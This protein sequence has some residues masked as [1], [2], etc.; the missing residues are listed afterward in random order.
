ME[1]ATLRGQIKEMEKE[2]TD[3]EAMKEP[4]KKPQGSEDNRKHAEAAFHGQIEKSNNRLI[5]KK[6]DNKNL[7]IILHGRIE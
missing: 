3:V 1:E 4:E 2:F 5:E 6:T 7:E